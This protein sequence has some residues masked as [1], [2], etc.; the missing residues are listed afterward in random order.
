VDVGQ[1]PRLFAGSQ[2]L[3]AGGHTARGS[4]LF[5]GSTWTPLSLPTLAQAAQFGATATIAGQVRLVAYTFPESGLISY[6]DGSARAHV[7]PPPPTSQVYDMTTF[8]GT[9][10]VLGDSGLVHYNGTAWVTD[11]SGAGAIGDMTVGDIGRGQRL[12]ITMSGP[13]GGGLYE[14]DG[15]IY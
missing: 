15:A 14:Y 13:M 7:T 11:I 2:F 9:L 10:Y 1:G 8:N 5:D 3:R 12:Y 4:A 6:W